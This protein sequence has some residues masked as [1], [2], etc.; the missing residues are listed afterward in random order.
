MNT[1]NW[2]ADTRRWLT[3]A[4]VV[5]QDTLLVSSPLHQVTAL[6]RFTGAE[7]WTAQVGDDLDA[8]QVMGDKALVRSHG[9]EG[10]VPGAGL[11]E[12]KSRDEL[13][14]LDLLT[15]DVAWKVRLSDEMGYHWTSPAGQLYVRSH[16]NELQRLDPATGTP[17]WSRP[18]QGYDVWPTF[19]PDGQ[20]MV[21]ERREDVGERLVSL[22]P[23]T[24][25][26]RWQFEGGSLQLEVGPQGQLG[27][28]NYKYDSGCYHVLDSAGQERCQVDTAVYRPCLFAG[29]RLIA[30]G[31]DWENGSL[32]GLEL[33]TGQAAWARELPGSPGLVVGL[34]DAVVATSWKEQGKETWVSSFD[35][36]S[37]TERWA[38]QLTGPVNLHTGPEGELLAVATERNENW[39]TSATRL[40]RLDPATGEVLW[41][42]ETPGGGRLSIDGGRVRLD[43]N[44]ARVQ[45]FDL[46][47]GQPAGYFQTGERLAVSAAAEDGTVYVAEHSGRVRPLSELAPGVG[48]DS[49]AV[50]SPGSGTVTYM[51]SGFNL[52]EGEKNGRAALIADFDYNG[53]HEA[54]DYVVTLDRNGDGQPE[55]D[56]PVTLGELRSF[57]ANGDGFVAREEA[58]NLSWHLWRDSNQDG[59]L[60]GDDFIYEMPRGSAEEVV[61]DVERMKIHNAYGVTREV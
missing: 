23:E 28:N 4:P 42:A 44:G 36:S 46:A 32:H 38:L 39:G 1:I 50:D 61:V 27:V 41:T 31:A 22:D 13:F 21:V 54:W 6:D 40:T 35:A 43:L 51:R 29:E 25:E 8:P 16:N 18:V 58:R 2:R 10:S 37:G 5:A 60:D 24:G 15:G 7:R 14:A 19:A 45:E 26:V 59:A 48:P 34:G 12:I 33:A 53:Q 9:V 49:D 52:F 55:L 20:V 57:D 30:Q 56:Q 3:D 11:P 47:T 17:L